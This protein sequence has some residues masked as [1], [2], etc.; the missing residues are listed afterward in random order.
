MCFFVE[1][2]IVHL[3]GWAQIGTKQLLLNLI[4]WAQIGTKQLL[5]NLIGWAQI[6]TKKLLLKIQ[7]CPTREQVQTELLLPK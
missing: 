2:A 7:S 6:G 5:L 1:R 3:I 4:G